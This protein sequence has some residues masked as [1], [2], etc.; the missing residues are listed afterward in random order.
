MD[1]LRPTQTQKLPEVF[2]SSHPT[3]QVLAG[4]HP[5]LYFVDSRSRSGVLTV[6]PGV[7]SRKGPNFHPEVVPVRGKTGLGQTE[8]DE[9]FTVDTRGSRNT[10]PRGRPGTIRRESGRNRR[11]GTNSHGFQVFLYT[12]VPRPYS[13]D[14]SRVLVGRPNTVT[15]PSR[16]GNETLS[17]RVTLVPPVRRSRP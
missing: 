9:R 5:D 4:T 10:V 12:V 17:L 11:Q 1:G 6:R 13:Q 3:N 2:P 15:D 8:E 7:L 16:S 14:G